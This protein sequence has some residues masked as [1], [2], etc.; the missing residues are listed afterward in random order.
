MQLLYISW[1][2]IG[3]YCTIKVQK[4]PH[5]YTISI[6]SL[7]CLAYSSLPHTADN[8]YY[9]WALLLELLS[10]HCRCKRNA[11]HTTCLKIYFLEGIITYYNSPM[12]NY[13]R[14]FIILPVWLLR[15]A[16]IHV[17]CLHL[18]ITTGSIC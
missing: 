2:N 12:Q 5:T 17:V 8:Y 11:C 16:Y 18:C 14:L 10:L 7:L 13:A 9:V 3:M 6:A 15:L 1:S 4:S